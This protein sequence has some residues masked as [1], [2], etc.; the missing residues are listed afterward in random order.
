MTPGLNYLLRLFICYVCICIKQTVQLRNYEHLGII[1]NVL[2]YVHKNDFAAWTS[3]YLLAGTFHSVIAHIIK[4]NR[5]LP[6]E[7]SINFWPWGSRSG[8]LATE[9]QGTRGLSWARLLTTYHIIV[10]NVGKV[11]NFYL[12]CTC[13]PRPLDQ[14]WTKLIVFVRNCCYISQH[15]IGRRGRGVFRRRT[16]NL[17][18]STLPT[19]FV[20][21]L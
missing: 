16:N 2:Y 11:T 17:F 10:K 8:C 7:L 6:I 4:A 1:V 21:D 9:L 20:R 15:W 18:W 3:T 19:T 14:C 13:P 12:S 5:V